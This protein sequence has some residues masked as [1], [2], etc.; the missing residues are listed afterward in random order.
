MKDGMMQKQKE[1]MQEQ[2]DWQVVRHKSTKRRYKQVDNTNDSGEQNYNKVTWNVRGFNQKVKHKEL[3]LFIKRNKVNLIAIY[4]HR[5]RD[6]RVSIIIKKNM[7]GWN[8]CT[9]ECNNVRGRIWVIWNPNEVT[10]TRKE[11]AVQYIHRLVMIKQRNIQF[12]FT[13]VYGLHTIATRL[14]LWTTIKQLNNNINEPWLIIGDFNS[15]LT[16]RD[17]PVGSP[18]QDIEIRDF[19]ECLLDCNLAELQIGGREYT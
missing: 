12:Q 1:G 19:R 5:V 9:N 8:W 7:A 6:E 16:Q 18:V 10:F 13:V 2:G 15:I 4:E 14:P 11:D 17:T 3:R